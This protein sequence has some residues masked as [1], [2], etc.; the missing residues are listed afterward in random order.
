[1]EWN[2]VRR[3]LGDFLRG[4]ALAGHEKRLREGAMDLQDLF[5]LVSFMDMLGLPNPAMLYLLEIYPYFLEEFHL[6][7]RRMGVDRSPLA[8]LACC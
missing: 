4:M 2:E 6:W 8:S 3:N 5:L 7:H 1:M